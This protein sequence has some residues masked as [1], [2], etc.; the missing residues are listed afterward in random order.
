MSAWIIYFLIPFKLPLN[1]SI[2]A[3]IIGVASS[4]IGIIRYRKQKIKE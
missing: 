1:T 2:F 3:Q 4:I